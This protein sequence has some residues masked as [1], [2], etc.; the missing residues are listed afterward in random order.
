VREI[1]WTQAGADQNWL[2][3]A[4]RSSV[5]LGRHLEE[6]FVGGPK[7]SRREFGHRSLW[8]CV[9]DH[10][11]GV[12]SPNTLMPLVDAISARAVLVQPSRGWLIS[13]VE[14][15]LCLFHVGAWSGR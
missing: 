1:Q 12:W 11:K 8:E 5:Y 10:P 6:M 15:G 4:M 9:E 7:V 2:A 14:E 13:D 3:S